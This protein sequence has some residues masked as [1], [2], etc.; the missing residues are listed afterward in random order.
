MDYYKEV[1]AILR[2]LECFLTK[3]D[4]DEA[5]EYIEHDECGVAI[6]LICGALVEDQKVIPLEIYIKINE[7][8]MDMELDKRGWEKIQTDRPK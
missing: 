3:A 6:E 8:G 1:G 5:Q 7:V 4:I 2:N